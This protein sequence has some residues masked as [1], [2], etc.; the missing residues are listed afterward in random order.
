MD[1]SISAPSSVSRLQVVE[2]LASI[3]ISADTI[4][5]V[6]VER[7]GITVE[8]Y[9]TDADGRRFAIGVGD[10]ARSAVHAVVIPITEEPS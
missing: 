6:H 3:G 2:W 4:R 5:A 8:S 1:V 10:E 9:A 7:D